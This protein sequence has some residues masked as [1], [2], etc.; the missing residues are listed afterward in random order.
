MPL[1]IYFFISIDDI[2]APQNCN[3]LSMSLKYP[4]LLLYFYLSIPSLTLLVY[5]AYFITLFQP[6]STTSLPSSLNFL[7]NPTCSL[8]IP[9]T[10]F[11]SIV[12]QKWQSID[13]SMYFCDPIKPNFWIF[14]LYIIVNIQLH[15]QEELSYFIMLLD[16]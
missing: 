7:K 16:C 8:L 1:T 9:Q 14:T 3:T 12:I 10:L 5:F 15:F 11:F 6:A 13:W 4:S 2:P